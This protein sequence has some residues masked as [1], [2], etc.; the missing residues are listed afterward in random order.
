MIME[1]CEGGE[2]LALMKKKR[3]FSESLAQFYIAQLGTPISRF[4]C[5]L[6]SYSSSSFS[7]S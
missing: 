3:V 5:S 7:Y 4:S 6:F 2:I 1:L